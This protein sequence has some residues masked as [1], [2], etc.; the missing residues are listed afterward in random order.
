VKQS[1]YRAS[2]TFMFSMYNTIC[3]VGVLPNISSNISHATSSI[4]KFHYSV[5]SSTTFND[6]HLHLINHQYKE[7]I[8]TTQGEEEE[9]EEEEEEREEEG[10]SQLQLKKMKELKNI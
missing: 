8:A 4:S 9:E 3:T 10:E 2:C 1:G 7:R 5:Y 6:S